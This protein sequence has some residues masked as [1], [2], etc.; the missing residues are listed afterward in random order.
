MMIF[1]NAKQKYLLI[2]IFLFFPMLAAQH[3]GMLLNVTPS[4]PLGI[5]ARSNGVI[6]RGSIVT[7]CLPDFYKTLAL[8]KLYIQKGRRCDG[9][10]PL[11]KEVI[12]VPGDH[13]FL[14]NDAIA[15][16]GKR[17]AYPT[18]TK[19]SRGER[20]AALSTAIEN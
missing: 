12:A 5:Y 10:E 11:I 9:A 3:F 17:Y 8:N 19:D 6:Q 20:L 4:M 1:K 2:P 16:N 15:V 13:V 18:L 7:F 14:T